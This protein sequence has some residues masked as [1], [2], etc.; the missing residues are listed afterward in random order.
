MGRIEKSLT[1][2]D[3]GR[4]PQPPNDENSSLNLEFSSKAYLQHP[5]RT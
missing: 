4:R 3:I 2:N 1:R 5:N